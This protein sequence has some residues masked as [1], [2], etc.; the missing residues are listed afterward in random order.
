M[1]KMFF[2]MTIVVLSVFAVSCA[3]APAGQ[4]GPRLEIRNLGGEAVGGVDIVSGA[5]ALLFAVPLDAG[6]RLQA[7]EEFTFV[8]GRYVDGELY[9]G[10][11]FIHGEWGGIRVGRDRSTRLYVQLWDHVNRATV[12]LIQAGSYEFYVF[13]INGNVPM[14]NPP[15]HQSQYPYLDGAL[16]TVF[17]VTVLP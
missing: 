13:A 16:N 8:L 10:D 7:G 5:S 11:R 2:V 15:V 1:R 14:P 17:T 6:N 9:V 4:A 3:T 12:D